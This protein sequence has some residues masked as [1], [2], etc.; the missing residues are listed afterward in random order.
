MLGTKAGRTSV[1]LGLLMLSKRKMASCG[2]LVLFVVC[3]PL[4]NFRKICSAILTGCF[5]R[6]AAERGS[7]WVCDLGGVESHGITRAGQRV[8]SRLT[9]SSDWVSTCAW[10]GGRAQQHLPALLPADRAALTL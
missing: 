10:V 1:E 3:G 2:W 8:L 4:K 6:K 7:V 9:E 5:C